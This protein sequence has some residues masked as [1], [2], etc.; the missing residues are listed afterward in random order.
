MRTR[1]LT[2]LASV[3][4]GAAFAAAPATAQSLNGYTIVLG[5]TSDGRPPVALT[6]KAAGAKLRVETDGLQML[7][8]GGGG[9]GGGAGGMAAGL[10]LLPLDSGKVAAILPAMGMGLSVDL[11]MVAGA[12]RGG[13]GG[14]G[15]GGARG[16]GGGMAPPDVPDVTDVSANVDDLGAGESILGHPTHKYRIRSTYMINGEKQADTSETWFA[17]DLTGSD[18]GFGKFFT[19]FGAAFSGG[20]SS[21][22]VADAVRAKMPKGFPVKIITNSNTPQGPVVTTI[23]ASEITKTSFEPA[24]FE[25]PAGIQ[26]MDTGSLMGGRRGGKDQ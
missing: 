3:V 26:L 4:I 10:Y 22:S 19:T 11:S 2:S 23:E 18:D 15:R 5:I 13:R 24:D 6:L 20:N 8:M 21:K 25:V 9:G 7:G 14:R 16:A 1:L 12:G 17:T